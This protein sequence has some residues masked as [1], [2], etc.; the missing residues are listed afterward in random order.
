MSSASP[1]LAE[2]VSGSAVEPTLAPTPLPALA[3][4]KINASNQYDSM[5]KGLQSAKEIID[6]I[7]QACLKDQGQPTVSTK[8]ARTAA[9]DV[10]RLTIQATIAPLSSIQG[11]E[12]RNHPLII[13]AEA[14]LKR[15]DNI[16][17]KPAE[18]TVAYAGTGLAT[19]SRGAH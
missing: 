15:L 9:M 14:L 13:E 7:E 6:G 12:R 18:T 10:Q 2:P 11:Q 3:A 1:V 16:V 17:F 4:A 8:L 5:A 19:S